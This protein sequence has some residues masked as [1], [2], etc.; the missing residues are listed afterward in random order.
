MPYE[1]KMPD[2]A[3]T[4]SSIKIVRWLVQ[5][6]QS[7]SRGQS[8]LE[9]ETDKATM[10]VECT[11]DGTFDHICAEEG[12]S[13]ETGDV[14]AMIESTAMTAPST[15]VPPPSAPTS[16]PEVPA[17]AKKKPGG[18]FARNRD[19]RENPSGSPLPA[20]SAEAERPRP[21]GTARRTAARRLAESKNTI[22][23]FYLQTSF[24]AEAM[25]AARE[26]A[27]PEEPVWDAYFTKA[28]HI[29]LQKH[30]ELA[31]R[32]E[33]DALVPQET[34][35]IGVAVDIGGDLLVLPVESPGTRSVADISNWIR[36]R[37]AAL[38]GGDPT[39]RAMKPGV[40]T[41]TNL[42]GSNVET[43]TAIINPPEAAILAVG[44]I[45]PV[46][47]AVSKTAFAIQHRANITLSVDHRV[48]NG[49]S[50]ADFLGSLVEALENP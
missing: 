42:G 21:L 48:V 3:V 32:Y 18:L 31:F 39:A 15:A 10:E 5:P 13:V 2:L 41:I 23:H 44:K 11:T 38:R 30:S 1:M 28:V 6:G 40:M 9:V 17:T 4:G 47:V 16:S 26:A 29:A 36:G 50:A 19:S 43:F 8:L 22:P 46:V 20:K 49:K 37:V 12:Q 45:R 24:H 35:T 14:I 33:N 27:L 34:D 7:V 25:R